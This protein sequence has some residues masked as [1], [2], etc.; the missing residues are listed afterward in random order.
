MTH[1]QPMKLHTVSPS[2]G[3]Q[4]VRLGI[5]TFIRQPLA[6]GGLF[7]LFM[8]AVSVLSM[9]PVLGSALSLLILPAASLGLINAARLAS[10]G[11]FPLPKTLVTAF[12]AGPAKRNAMLQLGVLYTAAFLGVIGITMLIDGGQFAGLYMLGEPLTEGMASDASFGTALWVG[13]L[14]YIPMAVVFWHAPALVFWHDVSPGKSLFFSAMACWNN[15]GAMT[16]FILAWMG[17]I[18]FSS[19][20]VSVIAGL[21]GSVAVINML[22]MP[23]TMV[24][25]AM[26]FASIYFTYQDSFQG[27]HV[28][29]TTA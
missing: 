14:L 29:D 11:Q 5:K 17:I 24:L 18:T 10:T 19:L 21:L 8:G 9:V 1:N 16:M 4:W 20:V 15:K 13:L 27:T 6:L 3:I 23:A 25:A 22:L 26:F 12:T 2:Q 28:V 7:F